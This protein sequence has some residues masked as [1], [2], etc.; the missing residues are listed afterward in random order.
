VIFLPAMPLASVVVN[1]SKIRHFSLSLLAVGKSSGGAGFVV[2]ELLLRVRHDL[3]GPELLHVGDLLMSLAVP[4]RVRLLPCVSRVQVLAGPIN[5]T[6]AVSVLLICRDCALREVCRGFP[7]ITCTLCGDVSEL[8]SCAVIGPV[9][10]HVPWHCCHYAFS[11]VKH[12]AFVDV[13][14]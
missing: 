13:L 2:D 11:V 10:R 4:F 14:L 7:V 9:G 6:D 1:V 3:E 12:L 8:S 5:V